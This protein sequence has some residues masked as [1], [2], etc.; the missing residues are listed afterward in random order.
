MSLQRFFLENQVIADEQNEEFPLDLSPD[1]EKHLRVLRLALGEHI[2][3]VDAASDYFECE[4]RGFDG[5]TPI[6]AIA[7]HLD[8]PRKRP[9]VMLVQGMA[10]GE[11]MDSVIRHATELG[12]S[13]FLPLMCERSIVKLD[14]KKTATRMKRWDAI[15]KSAAMQSGQPRIPQV[16]EP[17]R[18]DTAC[19]ELAEATT[20]LVCWEEA[21]ETA[22]LASALARALDK[23]GCE[24]SEAVVAVVVGPEGGLSSREVDALLACNSR[25]ALV[26]LGSSILR[27]E[28][29]GLVAPALVLY[30]LGGLGKRS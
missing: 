4:I 17:A 12:V 28:T 30:E 25:S 21:P 16:L 22:C 6:V 20:V 2:A 19:K 8:A 26:S 11:K 5:A 13:T 9:R 23:T 15:A 14:A 18:L 3:V 27:T 10:K 7:Q 1:D 29:A 24:A